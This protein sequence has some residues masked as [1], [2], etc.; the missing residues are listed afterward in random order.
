MQPLQALKQGS[1]LEV[2]IAAGGGHRVRS[3][4]ELS[5][6]PSAVSAA[7]AGT[8]PRLA[9]SFEALLPGQPVVGAVQSVH[10]GHLFVAL[11]S[12]VRGR[13]HLLHA[14]PEPAAAPQLQAHFRVGQ[15]VRAR[16]LAVDAAA[17]R[18]DLSL[19]DDS[20]AAVV[21]GGA[22][23]MVRSLWL[24]VGSSLLMMARLLC[25]VPACWS[26]A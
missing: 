21:S 8:A 12:T 25:T 22:A 16:V 10:K 15:L 11:S 2:T 13:V 26:C 1:E 24:T 4:P 20:F 3:V 14:H 19:L 17:Q 23:A 9:A 18:L 5:A 7:R 6:R